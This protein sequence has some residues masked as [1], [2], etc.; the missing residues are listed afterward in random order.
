MARWAELSRWELDRKLL[1]AYCGESLALM[2]LALTRPDDPRLLAQDPSGT[3]TFSQIRTD[4]RLLRRL[5]WQGMGR[6][7]LAERMA[8]TY[9]PAPAYVPPQQISVA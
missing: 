8:A 7:W 5:S 1:G 3:S 6:H 9:A 2:R 4:R